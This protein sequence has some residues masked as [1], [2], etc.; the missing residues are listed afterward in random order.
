MIRKGG[1][2]MMM[3]LRRVC[4]LLLILI[5]ILASSCFAYG[6]PDFLPN[7][8]HPR[9]ILT[10]EEL[11][12]L[13]TKRDIKDPRWLT[14]QQWCET[15]L[16]DSG[17][18][19]Q[20]TTLGYGGIIASGL[21][22][23]DGNNS[24]NGYRMSGFAKHLLNYALAYQVLK[25]PGSGQDVNKA[26]VYA[27]RAR[28]LL[29][30]GVAKALNVGEE[31]NGLRALRVSDRGDTSVNSAEV[32]ALKATTES[33]PGQVSTGSYKNG[34][35]S[36]NL[37]AVPIAYDWIYDTL[38]NE[39]KALMSGMMLRWYD[40]IRGVRS[41][42]NNGVLINGIRYYED[43]RGVADS[44]NINTTVAGAS[45]IALDFGKM[46]ANYGV[47]HTSFQ[48]LV[49]IAL[50]G[51]STDIPNYLQDV[52]GILRDT[53]TAQLENDLL[54]S[55]GESIEGWNYGSSYNR[56]LISMFGYYTATGEPSLTTMAWPAALVESMAARLHSNLLDIPYT[57]YWT[58]S[59]LGVN[60]LS[61]ALPFTAVLQRV[62]PTSHLS[63]VGQYLLHNVPW[64]DR[65]A[66]FE[67][68]LWP[69]DDV[70]EAEPATLPLFHLAKGSGIFTSRSSWRDPYTV[71]LLAI[72]RGVGAQADHE[73][74]D[75]GHFA[76]ARGTDRLLSHSNG[77]GDA[78][79][80]ESFNTVVFNNAS[81]H[82]SNPPLTKPAIDKWET[83]AEYSYIS[84]DI[85]N[86]W[87]RPYKSDKALLFRRSMLHLLPGYVV[88]WDQTRSNSLVGN[89]KSWC[90]QHASQPTISGD[91]I[92]STVGDSKVF[93]RTLYPAGGTF[94]ASN[95][96]AGSYRVKYSPAVQQ[97]YDQFLHVI[98]ATAS[99]SDTMTLTEQVRS[100]EG[101]MV[102]AYLKNPANPAVIM[103]SADKDGGLVTGNVTYTL[104]APVAKKLL[105]VAVDLPPNAQY[106]VV[107]P[108]DAT[109]PQTYQ[110]IPGNYP[111]TGTV[112][113]TS[114]QGVL[115]IRTVLSKPSWGDD[116]GGW[117]PTP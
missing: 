104:S 6:P 11:S 116:K 58:G 22:N 78:P 73:G 24:Y 61:F 48:I 59:P 99:I 47:S 115:N 44:V 56:L 37:T 107:R 5:Q 52:R 8:P 111:N 15:H 106:T 101:K 20:P 55:G 103:F 40:W 70:V 4:P 2:K 10:A 46:Y 25:Q 35:P 100:A 80:S 3:S 68:L 92:S 54:Q 93:V 110:L 105:H 23:W 108:K 36:R 89:I 45:T 17:Y 83:A 65:A 85:T 69:V 42:Y 62:D 81:H 49:P 31:P 75:Q 90:T 117:Q 1:S 12:N 14:L 64:L 77:A 86:A 21:A 79:L 109:V 63:K 32:A 96:Y 13:K 113:T 66:E 71:H 94:S 28:L 7:G 84:A 102:G 41:N 98:E 27:S 19:I 112:Y 76:L 33:L 97:E 88:I 67:N 114:S 30:E 60:R 57:G 34:Y 74:Y 43:Q 95:P 38:S 53:V 39:D 82:A 87:K 26:G 16:Q 72:L 51:D 29:V 91:V 9:I 50:Y 18:N